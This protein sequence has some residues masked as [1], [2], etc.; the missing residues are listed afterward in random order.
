MENKITVDE[1][2]VLANNF[3]DYLEKELGSKEIVIKETMYWHVLA[4]EKYDVLN[5]PTDLGVGNLNDDVEF[6]K[7]L[8]INKDLAVLPNLFHFASLIDYLSN[9]IDVSV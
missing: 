8:L 1:L 2:R 7:A 5:Q 9:G 6:L 3:F 4:E